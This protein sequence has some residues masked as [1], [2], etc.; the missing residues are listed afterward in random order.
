MRWPG[1]IAAGIENHDLVQ[2]IDIV[3]TA[4]DL[5]NASI[6]A[7]INWM[8]KALSLFSGDKRPKAGGDTYLELGFGGRF[9]PMSTSTSQPYA[10]LKNI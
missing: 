10:S 4:F 1:K 2:S 5:G 8:G 7:N 9:V 6:P 3:A